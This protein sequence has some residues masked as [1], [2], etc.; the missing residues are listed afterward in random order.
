MEKKKEKKQRKEKK[1]PACPPLEVAI[2][3]TLHS[4]IDN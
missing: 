4:E 1:N 2:I 3:N